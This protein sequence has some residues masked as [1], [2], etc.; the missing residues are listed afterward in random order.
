MVRLASLRRYPLAFQPFGGLQAHLTHNCAPFVK[1]QAVEVVGQI[2]QREFALRSG[3]ADGA[4]EQ[5]IAVF[6]MRQD[7]L[8]AGADR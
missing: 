6:Q 7:M 1:Y 3:D 2:G 8:D 4:D 5:A